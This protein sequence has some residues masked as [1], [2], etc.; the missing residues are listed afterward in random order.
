MHGGQ[1]DTVKHQT[2]ILSSAATCMQALL[3][4][5]NGPAMSGSTTQNGL[6][7]ETQWLTL[8]ASRQRAAGPWMRCWSHWNIYTGV[9]CCFC[10]ERLKG[11]SSETVSVPAD[12]LSGLLVK[13]EKI[14]EVTRNKQSEEKMQQK[15]IRGKS[16]KTAMRRVCVR[17]V[18]V[19]QC[20]SVWGYW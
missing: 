7:W 2:L 1:L 4:P 8:R 9:F 6:P 18:W 11:E 15:C 13:G 14:R 5:H 3:P 19:C 12:S 16:W 10:V 20:L 17:N